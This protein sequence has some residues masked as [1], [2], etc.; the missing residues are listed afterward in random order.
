MKKQRTRYTHE[1]PSYHGPRIQYIHRGRVAFHIVRTDGRYD[2][3][4]IRR[5]KHARRI[6][7]LVGS[8]FRLDSAKQ[9][10][11]AMVL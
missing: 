8:A 7:R 10:I 9:L 4:H 5:K 2:V 3:F 11:Q 6:R 1:E